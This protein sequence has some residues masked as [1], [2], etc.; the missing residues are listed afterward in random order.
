MSQHLLNTLSMRSLSSESEVKEQ[1]MSQKDSTTTASDKP[2]KSRQVKER[3]I[4]SRHIRV[5]LP[6]SLLYRLSLLQISS[7]T[8]VT[9]SK[10]IQTAIESYLKQPDIERII[11]QASKSIR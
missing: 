3:R 2:Q 4:D 7:E 10:I 5:T 11:S 9:R 8:S 6:A 1:T